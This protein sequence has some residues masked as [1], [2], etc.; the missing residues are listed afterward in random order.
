MSK[1]PEYLQINDDHIVITLQKGADIDGAIV[2]ELTMREP[3]VNDN[4]VS[5]AVK[6]GD[7]EKELTMFG[8]LCGI[9]PDDLKK[10]TLRDY[11]RVQVA[12]TNFID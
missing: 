6:G 12:F 8:N 7:A 3:T 9:T 11:K 10:L 4:L 1:T 5:D 2:K